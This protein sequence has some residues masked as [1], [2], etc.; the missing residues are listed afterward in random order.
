MTEAKTDGVAALRLLRGVA[1]ELRGLAIETARLGESLA[2]DSKI[3]EATEIISLLQYFDVF[4]QNL[5]AHAS[6]IDRLSVRLE[7]GAA[8]MAAL[9]DLIGGIP[10]FR[11][12]ERLRLNVD[13]S[14][15]LKAS[16]AVQDEH[17]G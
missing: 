13:G 3:S 11:I 12:R 8:D 6:L 7:T 10:F 15:S 1:N 17:W 16:E 4:A 2:P 5:E 9:H 14:G